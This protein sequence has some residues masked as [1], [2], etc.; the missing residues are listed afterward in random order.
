MTPQA[1]ARLSIRGNSM[2]MPRRLGL[3]L[4][5]VLAACTATKDKVAEERTDSSVTVREVGPLVIDGIPEIPAELLE[6][7]RRYQ[8]V[9]SAA[10]MGWLDD[11]LLITTRFAETNQVHRVDAPLGMRRQLTFATEP[12]SQAW[13]SPRRGAGYVYSRDIG[14]SEFYQLFRDDPV[15]HETTLLTDGRSRYGQ[16]VWTHTGDRFAY[17]TTE[18]NGRDWDVHIQGLDGSKTIALEA[19][20][21]WRPLDF[22]PDGQ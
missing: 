8:N 2:V 5:C 6:R 21:A 20:G 7:L 19:E 1:Y 17:S 22:S 13:P 3:M 16:V 14:G 12:I 11:A 4:I 9:R 18:R 15:T 10:L